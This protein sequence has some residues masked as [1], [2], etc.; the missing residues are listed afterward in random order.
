MVAHGFGVAESYHQ[1]IAAE[2]G[3]GFVVESQKKV[4]KKKDTA[5]VVRHIAELLTSAGGRALLVGG[6]VRDSLLGLTSKDFDME[7]YGLSMEAIR[8]ILSKEYKLDFVGMAFGVL[9]VLHYDIDI[10]LPRVENKTNSGHK[11]FDV[12]FVPN[13]SYAD[14][15]SRRDFTINAIMRDPLSNELIDPWNGVKD[16]HDGILRHVS[17]HF[18][19]DPLRVLR[20]MQFAARFDFQI[21]KE[22]I[23]LCSTLSQ[24]ELAQERVAAEWEKLLLKGRKPSKG[25]SFLRDCGWIDY[26]PEL[27][28]LIGCKQ[29]PE[30]HPEGDVWEHTLRV[31][32]AAAAMR[33]YAETENLVLMLAAL[34]HDFGKPSTTTVDGR[35]RIISHGHDEAGVVPAESFIR[36]IWNK[37]ELD[38]VMPLVKRHMLPTLFFQTNAP[39]RAYRR[40]SLEVRSM[41]LLADL[42]ECDL[43]GVE[44]PDE[45]LKEK[46]A[47]IDVFRERANAL[48]VMAERPKPIVLGRHLMERGIKPGPQMKPI[49][50]KCFDAQLNGE[51]NDLPKALE[52]LDSLLKERQN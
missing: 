51:F 19:E 42:A 11:G 14:A 29:E 48:N 7:V 5:A 36:R 2:G 4:S 27:K 35:G 12:M 28:A 21:A 43:R 44:M 49:L 8:D 41:E 50:D 10:A 30:W 52:Y 25:L 24:D 18:V 9:K 46:I 17:S 47:R 20:A 32:D 13:L 34:C 37:K 39:D 40:L 38:D 31:L 26:Y 23:S 22:T 15:A 1:P 45:L 16:L 33:H 3:G 6:C